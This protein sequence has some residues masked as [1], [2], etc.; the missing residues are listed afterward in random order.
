MN[1]QGMDYLEI[2]D[3]LTFSTFLE[4][5]KPILDPLEMVFVEVFERMK[6]QMEKA[7]VF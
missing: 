3:I 6:H 2:L 5:G 1:E 4:V 7:L